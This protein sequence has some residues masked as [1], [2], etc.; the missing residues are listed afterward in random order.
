MQNIEKSKIDQIKQMTEEGYSARKIA[1][2]LDIKFTKVKEIVKSNEFSIKKELFDY[3]LI[4]SI[5]RLYELGVSAKNLGIKFSIDKRR[6]QR[7]A[8]EKGLLRERGGD[9]RLKHQI[10]VKPITAKKIIESI[11]VPKKVEK[12]R[13]EKKISVLKPCLSENP[14]LRPEKKK[15]VGEI[16]FPKT[17]NISNDHDTLIYNDHLIWKGNKLTDKFLRTVDEEARDEIGKDIFNFY[18][19]YDFGN[20]RVP[21]DRIKRSMLSLKAYK[22]KSEIIDDIVYLSNSGTTGYDVYKGFFPN[23]I[24]IKG[25]GRPSVYDVVTNREKLWATIRNRLGNTLLWNPGGG[26][27]VQFPMNQTLSQLLIGAKNSGLASMGSIFKPTV[28]KAIYQQWAGNDFNVLDYSCGFGTRLLGLMGC[29]FDN[30]KYF[31]YE[32][33]TE[34]YNGLIKMI[35]YFDFDAKIKKC[36]S[37][38]ECF[39]EKMDLAFSSP[40]YWTQEI[41]SDE[42]TQCYNK[43]TE[44]KDWLKGYWRATV[45]NINF[46][47]KDDGVF[48]INIGGQS[49][50]LMQKLADD[51]NKIIVDEGFEL[52]DTWYMKTSKSHLSGKKNNPNKKIKLEGIFFYKKR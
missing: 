21:E 32:P 6:V 34:T 12:V 2:N 45:K 33:N 16:N 48:G 25:V 10:K 40:P 19:K 50:P 22:P 37:E 42:A 26:T 28:A 3:D 44:Y 8:K 43:F 18:L 23:I 9:N 24:K 4:D 49:N 30:V 5:I 39:S 20:F 11:I 41:Y 13:V 15:W 27:P 47:L 52:T 46:M 36:G 14:N 17:N 38:V 1:R 51:L 29:G 7:W 35:D 31:G